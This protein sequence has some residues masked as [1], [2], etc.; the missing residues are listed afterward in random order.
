MPEFVEQPGSFQVVFLKDIYTPE[1][2]RRMG[3]NERQIKAVLYV[4][5]HGSIKNREY[6]EPTCV[7]KRTA[8]DDLSDLVQRGIL[9]KVGGQRGRG[10]A[11]RLKIGRIGQ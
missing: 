10:T 8:S 9:I 1:R 11:Y 4:K 2:L 7:S 3:L 6:M 5:E